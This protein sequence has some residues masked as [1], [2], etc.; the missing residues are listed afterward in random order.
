MYEDTVEEAIEELVVERPDSWT[1]AVR[2]PFLG[3]YVPKVG[4]RFERIQWKS[5]KPWTEKAIASFVVA[6]V[7]EGP[8]GLILLN[9]DLGGRLSVTCATWPYDLYPVLQEVPKWIQPGHVVDLHRPS[10]EMMYHIEKVE[11]GVVTLQRPGGFRMTVPLLAVCRDGRW[12]PSGN[13]RIRGP[14]GLL[15]VRCWR[16][17]ETL[18]RVRLDP[19]DS[20]EGFDHLLVGGRAL[21]N[22]GY[23]WHAMAG[24][25]NPL[26]TKGA[27]LRY[28]D[29]RYEVSDV[30]SFQHTFDAIQVRTGKLIETLDWSL[31]EG[32]TKPSKWDDDF[33]SGLG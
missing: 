2:G 16:E 13:D 28:G 3:T 33:W 21:L 8:E 20:L 5:R 14:D 10:V 6:E 9:G 29:E 18:R 19:T 32:W 22:V 12:S 17:P 11:G 7:G 23:D 25:R 15:Y 30:C 31:G 27:I 26:V 1:Y 4:D 24:E